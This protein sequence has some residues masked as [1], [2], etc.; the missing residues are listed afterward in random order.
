MRDETLRLVQ[1]FQEAQLA[2]PPQPEAIK[3]LVEM[4]YRAWRASRPAADEG[5][6]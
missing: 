1:E 2:R 4:G 3:A 6:D 5:E